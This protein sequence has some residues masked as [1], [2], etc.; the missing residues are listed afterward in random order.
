MKLPWL[1]RSR[2]SGFKEKKNVPRNGDKN[3]VSETGASET[4]PTG[5]SG[6]QSHLA[7]TRRNSGQNFSFLMVLLENVEHGDLEAA[8]IGADRPGCYCLGPSS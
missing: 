3:S 1:E 2:G 8:E 7:I 5:T 4:A 6:L